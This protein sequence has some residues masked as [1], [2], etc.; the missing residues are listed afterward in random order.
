MFYSYFMVWWA[1][2]ISFE[3]RG[4]LCSVN[5]QNQNQSTIQHN[6]HREKTTLTII[7]TLQ[8]HTKNFED[9]PKRKISADIFIHCFWFKKTNYWHCAAKTWTFV[10]YTWLFNRLC[11]Q[12]YSDANVR[13]RDK[14]LKCCIAYNKVIS[15]CV[16]KKCSLRRALT[17]SIKTFGGYILKNHLWNVIINSRE[18]CCNKQCWYSILVIVCVYWNSDNVFVLLPTR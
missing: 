5:Q 17:R 7:S 12:L 14:T 1:T 15:R 9:L 6:K 8:I 10:Y 2:L 16:L 3:Y 13:K 11:R 4:A 18:C